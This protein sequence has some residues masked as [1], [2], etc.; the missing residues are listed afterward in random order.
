MRAATLL[1]TWATMASCCCAASAASVLPVCCQWVPAR[2][3]VGPPSRAQLGAR[4]A[5][6][7]R[8]HAH[9]QARTHTHMSASMATVRAPRVCAPR[10]QAAD[11]ILGMGDNVNA[12]HSQ[13]R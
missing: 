9:M 4:N 7:M 2:G 10:R 5:H 6:A 11:G 1:C 8:T 12:F 3:H 13:V